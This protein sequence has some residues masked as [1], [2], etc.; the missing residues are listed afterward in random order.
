MRGRR[1]YQGN[2]YC[3]DE[4]PYPYDGQSYKANDGYRNNL[5]PTKAK[6]NEENMGTSIE[7]GLGDYLLF[8]H[9]L[10]V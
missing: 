3:R 7:K 5:K 4:R 1:P 9:K 10:R 6:I 2:E 8:W